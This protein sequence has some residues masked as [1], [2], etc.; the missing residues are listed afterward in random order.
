MFT[1]NKDVNIQTTKNLST[2]PKSITTSKETPKA[3]VLV[4]RLTYKQVS[5]VAYSDV[6]KSQVSNQLRTLGLLPP[7]AA[8]GDLSIAE[9][10]KKKVGDD[11][12]GDLSLWDSLKSRLDSIVSSIHET[13]GSTGTSLIQV[14]VWSGAILTIG[15]GAHWL[16][17]KYNSSYNAR[18]LRK[19]HEKKAK[20]L[21][22]LA[23]EVHDTPL[24][25]QSSGFDEF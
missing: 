12:E 7:A 15:I 23:K 11:M 6:F 22:K 18:V 21:K 19:K 2:T 16:L 9:D 4:D 8:D 10:A 14:F 20:K 24:L 5:Q 25:Q 1:K 17:R 13:L 3:P